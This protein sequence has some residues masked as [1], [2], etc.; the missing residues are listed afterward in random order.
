MPSDAG[1]LKEQARDKS[2]EL[3][4]KEALTLHTA[5]RASPNDEQHCLIQVL[6]HLWSVAERH[7]RSQTHKTPPPPPISTATIITALTDVFCNT[8]A[9]IA[10]DT[11]RHHLDQSAAYLQIV[12][13]YVCVCVWHILEI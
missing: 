7:S 2:N 8:V 3:N 10:V 13:V 9:P 4:V 12:R 11:W 6:N 1:V 5:Q